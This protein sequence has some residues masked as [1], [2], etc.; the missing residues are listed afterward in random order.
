MKR[1]DCWLWPGFLLGGVAV[2]T[3]A[4]T[5]PVPWDEAL[6]AATE[7]G[8]G[9]A[10]LAGI[11]RYRPDRPLFWRLT[12]LGLFAFA[13]THL[14]GTRGPGPVLDQVLLGLAFLL[15]TVALLI[16]AR[17][18]SQPG[19]HRANLVDGA[20]VMIGVM[21]GGWSL[22]IGPVLAERWHSPTPA[23]VFAVY[24]LLAL[25]RAAAAAVVLLA[26]DPRNRAHQLVVAGTLL[27]FATDIAFASAMA[28]DRPPATWNFVA[29]IVGHLIVAAAALHPSM[30]VVE[31]SGEPQRLTRVRLGLFAALTALYPLL[32]GLATLN[33]LAGSPP[34]GPPPGAPPVPGD[35]SLFLLPMLL[36]IGVSVLLVLR[37]GMIGNLAQRRAHQLDVAL[38]EQQA[39]RAELEHRATHDPLTGLGNRAALTEAL[40]VA[41]DR[42]A[43]GR[44]WLLLLD[45]DGFKE[46]ND[47]LGHP[48]GDELLVAL[49]AEFRRT[50]P[51]AL[52]ARL[53]GDEFAVI[54]P[55]HGSGHALGTADAL[56]AAAAREHVVGGAPVRVSASI[57]VL[58]LD[59]A[60]TSAD[61]LR[62]ADVALYAAKAAGRARYRVHT[63]EGDRLHNHTPEGDRDHNHTP[64]GDRDR[65]RAATGAG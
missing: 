40:A 19:Q 39:L 62:D 57:G 12:A 35:L 38:R 45:L 54:V 50:A 34:A 6:L 13:G 23:A 30:A 37:M 26:G 36:G 56:L 10:V 49:G 33:R 60:G 48:V 20:M 8:A 5:L 31:H 25:V 58:H 22:V 53:G 15:F 61:A 42:P 1:L 2:V 46:V 7:A 41:V 24:T 44:G 55:D 43:G 59:D 17:A 28:W 9:A 52:V 65:N 47:T 64:E 21:A 11:R 3:A 63:P 32:T 4:L 51:D 27:G 14:D 16:R 29:W 18:C